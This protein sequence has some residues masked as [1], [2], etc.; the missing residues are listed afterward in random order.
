MV[1]YPG[2]FGNHTKH[3]CQISFKHTFFL[4]FVVFITYV[5]HFSISK[6][7]KFLIIFKGNLIASA[8]YSIKKEIKSKEKKVKLLV[9]AIESC[10]YSFPLILSLFIDFTLLHMPLIMLLVL[11]LVLL[12]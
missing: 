9:L 11:Y 12:I 10:A 4:L 6:K 7:K 8:L 2:H 1:H 5:F 3:T